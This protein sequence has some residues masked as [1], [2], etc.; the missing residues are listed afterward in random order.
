M[1]NSSEIHNL[2]CSSCEVCTKSR[3]FGKCQI[4]PAKEVL[5]FTPL[6]IDWLVCQQDDRKIAERISTKTG[7][8]MALRKKE[9]I[10][11]NVSS[12]FYYIARQGIFRH[13][14]S[15]QGIIYGS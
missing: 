2:N 15:S 13:Y 9:P 8:K 5:F 7:W 6:V 4:T 14:C 12:L 1:H 11:K 3:K 10:Q